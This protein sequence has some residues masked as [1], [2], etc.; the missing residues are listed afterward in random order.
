[1]KEQRLRMQTTQDLPDD[2]CPD[3]LVRSLFSRFGVFGGNPERRRSDVSIVT[4]KALF[5]FERVMSGGASGVVK[6]DTGKMEAK[7]GAYLTG[8]SG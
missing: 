3:V 4:L 5:E 7:G 8:F 2:G 6:R 1:M